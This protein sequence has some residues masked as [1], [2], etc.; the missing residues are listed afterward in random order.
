[1]KPI[2]FPEVNH[3]FTGD[4]CGD[5]PVMA[6]P[7]DR[8]DIVLVSCWEVTDADIQK[9]QDSGRLWVGVIGFQPPMLVE[10]VPPFTTDISEFPE[11]IED[12]RD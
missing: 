4:G 11:T 1:M 6:F 9:M 7:N 3:N 12:E 5:L 10:T 2:N 8:G